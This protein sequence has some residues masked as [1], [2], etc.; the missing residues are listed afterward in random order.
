M[1]VG[2]FSS[3]SVLLHLFPE[4]EYTEYTGIRKAG[5]LPTFICAAAAGIRERPGVPDAEDK[6]ETN[7]IQ[8]SSEFIQ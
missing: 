5:L 6:D 2:S 4:I 3:L 1:H 8:I 7:R